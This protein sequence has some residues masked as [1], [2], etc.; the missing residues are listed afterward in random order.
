MRNE[1]DDAALTYTEVGA[2]NGE[3]PEGYHR[4]RLR[5]RIGHGRALFDRA[6]AE[7]LAYRMQ[8]GTGIFRNASTPTAEVGT[9]L[10]VRLGLGP[11]A[12]TAPCRVVYVLDDTDRRGFAYGTLSGHPEIGEELFAVE[13]DP[14]D[15][16][17]YGLV[18]AFSRPGSWYTRLGGPVVR[19]IQHFI[20][21]RYI[22]TLPRSA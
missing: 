1:P 14:A 4:F 12:I 11:L 15:D 2:T 20:A 5:R 22:G 8:K 21:G 18:T 3:L 6:G 16:S 19:L 10:T 17:V 9:H 7:I 13:Y